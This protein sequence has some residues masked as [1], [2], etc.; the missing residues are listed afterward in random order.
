[1]V[2]EITLDDVIKQGGVDAALSNWCD[3]SDDTSCGV[4]GSSFSTSGPGP[5]WTHVHDADDFARRAMEEGALYYLDL[6][7]GRLA[8]A[9]TW[10]DDLYDDEEIEWTDEAVVR[11]V[12][13]DVE[14]VMESLAALKAAIE[15]EDAAENRFNEL[16][17]TAAWSQLS[18]GDLWERT[19]ESQ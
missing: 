19:N 17:D 16:S 2:I 18:L 5:G 13:P 15:M 8:S 9:P 3:E 12:C 1:M 11:L 4:I 7:D 10:V 14:S 6:D